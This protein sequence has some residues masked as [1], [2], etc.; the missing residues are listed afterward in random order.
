MKRW[1]RLA[2][3]IL[4]MLV[5]VVWTLQGLGPFGG[6]A[7]TGVRVWAV[8]GAIVAAVGAV[9]CVAHGHERRADSRRTVRGPAG[10]APTGQ[11]MNGCQDRTRRKRTPGV[12]K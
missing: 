10:S 2:L 5:G 9:T 6:S 12:V 1:L 7:M 11:D 8:I 4:A 3:G